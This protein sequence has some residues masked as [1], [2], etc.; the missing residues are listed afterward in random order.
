MY[1]MKRTS[2]PT[3]RPYSIRSTS[4]SSLTPRMMTL[5]IFSE[6]K[7]ARA[8]ASMPA[9]TAACSSNRVSVSKRRRIE[10]IEADGDAVE[11]RV[12]QRPGLVGQEHAIGGQ[13][14]IPDRRQGRELRNEARQLAPQQ[15]LTAR[16]TDPVDADLAEGA[17][18]GGDFLEREQ[19]L[20]RQPGVV[21]LGHAVV[22]A[23]VA[24]VGDRHAQAPQRAAEAIDDGDSHREAFIMPRSAGRRS[25]GRQV[26][27]PLVPGPTRLVGISG[28]ADRG[29]PPPGYADQ[30]SSG[31]VDKQRR[32]SM[33]L[34]R[35]SG[36]S[37]CGWFG[38]C[39][40]GGAAG[41]GRGEARARAGCEG[42]S[43]RRS[44]EERGGKRR[45]R[46]GDVHAADGRSDLQLR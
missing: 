38:R 2:A 10:R 19:R 30:R 23:Q 25:A 44:A 8:A 18:E 43:A 15:R 39:G 1:S 45:R 31:P 21:H 46:H 9:S 29:P 33:S 28:Q 36:G 26:R 27:G 40:A 35:G 14:E 12:A 16:N 13:R 22:A 3:L 32:S 41:A 34:R 5:S 6:S 17:G 24:A 7:P 20:A 4:S 37:G 11:A 42:R